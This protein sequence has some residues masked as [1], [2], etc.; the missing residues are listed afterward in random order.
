MRIGR[1]F[2]TTLAVALPGTTLAAPPWHH[3]DYGM[4]LYLGNQEWGRAEMLFLDHPNIA[5][6]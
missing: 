2:G 1:S 5:L 3:L 6:Q 4:N